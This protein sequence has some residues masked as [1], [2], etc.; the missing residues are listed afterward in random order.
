MQCLA[1]GF[2]RP[3]HGLPPDLEAAE[4]K[5]CLNNV[6]LLDNLPRADATA[7]VVVVGLGSAAGNV[8]QLFGKI[9]VHRGEV[10][11]GRHAAVGVVGEARRGLPDCG[12]VE[13]VAVLGVGVRAGP[14]VAVCPVDYGQDVPDAVVF[15]F[16]G[17]VPHGGAVLRAYL[18]GV[19]A[20]RL[21]LAVRIHRNMLAAGGLYQPVQSV[22]FKFLARADGASVEEHRLL[23]VVVNLRD[24][25]HGI[26]SVVEVLQDVRTVVS[27]GQEP[28]QAECILVVGVACRR[29]VAVLDPL[30]LA[31]RIVVDILDKVRGGT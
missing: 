30:A 2:E 7:V 20:F 14:R 5:A 1:L 29:A 26:V 10:R 6:V 25:A 3:V 16:A 21:G 12:T 13:A 24:I 22:V 4:V 9:P 11:H 8:A 27:R 23:G 31:L 17:V 18:G 19:V 15:P 28:F